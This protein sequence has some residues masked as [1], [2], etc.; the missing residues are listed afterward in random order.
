MNIEP[1]FPPAN[2]PVN[3]GLSKVS[4]HIALTLNRFIRA[5]RFDKGPLRVI[6]HEPFTPYLRRRTQHDLGF[7]LLDA[8]NR[9]LSLRYVLE[10]FVDRLPLPQGKFINDE[11]RRIIMQIHSESNRRL[12]EDYDLGLKQYGYY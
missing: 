9:R 4:G 10:T 12:D 8:I 1:Y 6:P 5:P 7:R 2:I 11:K 3:R